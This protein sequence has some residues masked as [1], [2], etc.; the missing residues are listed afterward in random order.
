MG[1]LEDLAAGRLFAPG[2]E[3]TENGINPDGIRL[4]LPENFETG[5]RSGDLG[6]GVSASGSGDILFMLLSGGKTAQSSGRIGNDADARATLIN[7]SSYSID[8]NLP[9]GGYMKATLDRIEGSK[10]VLLIRDEER[11]K[12]D[13]P[14]ELLPAGSKEGDILDITIQ[15]DEKATGDARIRTSDLIERLKRKSTSAQ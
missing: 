2:A 7:D 4:A 15:R 3:G 12:V 8:Q 10:A 1:T 13:L 9:C 14:I 5:G 6:S 11:I